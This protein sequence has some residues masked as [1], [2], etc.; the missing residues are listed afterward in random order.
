MNYEMLTKELAALTEGSKRLSDERRRSRSAG[1]G[2]CRKKYYPKTAR[3][4][5]I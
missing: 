2:L 1:E 3:K 5:I 4:D